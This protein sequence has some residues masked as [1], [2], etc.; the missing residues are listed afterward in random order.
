MKTEISV[1]EVVN[2]LS[3]LHKAMRALTEQDVYIGVPEDKTERREGEKEP[4][5]NAYLSYIHEHGVAEK[6]IPPRP[7]LIPGIEDIQPEA[8]KILRQA[9]KDAL[10]GKANAVNKALNRIGLLGQNAVRARFVDNDWPELADST[11]GSR[12]KI[13][14]KLNKKGEV[15]KKYGKSRQERGRVNP[16]I[17]TNQLRIAHIYVIKRRGADVEVTRGDE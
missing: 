10:K 17:D 4:M 2:N 12:K 9:A 15:I 6:G 13:S 1:S 14:E 11:L 8:V 5:T 3:A 16:L 7:H